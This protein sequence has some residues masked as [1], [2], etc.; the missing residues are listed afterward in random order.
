[1]TTKERLES[2][3]DKMITCR[4]ELL[5]QYLLSLERPDWSPE[6]SH[7]AVNTAGRLH[8]CDRHIT[9]LTLE[10]KQVQSGSGNPGQ[11]AGHAS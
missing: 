6:T 11:G 1:M 4:E 7:E 8:D 10:L 2:A 3:L 9:N 5:N